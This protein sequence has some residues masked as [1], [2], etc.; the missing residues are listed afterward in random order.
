MSTQLLVETANQ[1]LSSVEAPMPQRKL[2]QK[3]GNSTFDWT[4]V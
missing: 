3:T 4:P 2:D 1:V